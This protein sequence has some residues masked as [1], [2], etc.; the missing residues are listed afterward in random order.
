MPALAWL[1]GKTRTSAMLTCA[2]RAATHTISSAIS[3]AVTVRVEGVSDGRY[4]LKSVKL[5][6][7]KTFIHLLRRSFIAAEAN[8]RELCLDHS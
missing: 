5:T 1:I 7:F 8:D 6:W 3:S 4:V 2:G